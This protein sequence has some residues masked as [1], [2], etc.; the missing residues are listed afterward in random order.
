MINTDAL[1]ATRWRT[2]D[3]VRT[4]VA[5]PPAGVLIGA[6]RLLNQVV[7]PALGPRPV[8]LGVL[9]DQR[10]AALLAYRLLGVG[11]LL[12]VASNDPARWRRLLRAAGA[13]AVVGSRA[14]EW[15]PASN[16]PHLL[17]SDLPQAPD[18][19]LGDRS[20]CTVVHVAPRLPAGSVHWAAVDGVITAGTGHGR[21]LARVLRRP[22]AIELDAVGPGQLG[23][24]DDSRAVAVTP[25]LADAERMLLL[26]N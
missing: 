2:A 18:P 8:R 16:G 23:V 6:D 7:L 22:E 12:A 3:D 15:P 17:V 1:P 20:L 26:G 11:C 5:A 9:G 24:L 25:I 19:A 4:T 13:R 14:D 21:S 10:I